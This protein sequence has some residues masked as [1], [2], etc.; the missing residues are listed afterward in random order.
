[1]TLDKEL[2]SE[3]MID[4]DIVKIVRK[5]CPESSD[6]PLLGLPDVLATRFLFWNVIWK[7]LNKLG[8]VL[9]TEG[10]FESP[11]IVLSPLESI[12]NTM[13]RN[14]DFFDDETMLL[15]SFSTDP[16]LGMQKPIQLLREEIEEYIFQFT[17]LKSALAKPDAELPSDLPPDILSCNKTTLRYLESRV[18]LQVMEKPLHM[19]ENRKERDEKEIMLIKSIVAES[20]RPDTTFLSRQNSLNALQQTVHEQQVRSA[21][22][23][24]LKGSSQSKINPMFSKGFDPRP[25]GGTLSLFEREQLRL[26]QMPPP[27]LSQSALRP[28]TNMLNAGM[29]G[30]SSVAPIVSRAGDLV[31]AGRRGFPLPCVANRAASLASIDCNNSSKNFKLSWDEIK[32]AY[33]EMKTPEENRMLDIGSSG[34]V[35]PMPDAFTDVMHPRKRLRL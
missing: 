8:W 32:N 18:K 15:R 21:I 30:L 10:N 22:E 28:N 7:Q 24:A 16:R 17:L 23:Q 2:V 20:E 25:M 34:L 6:T 13:K 4:K 31:G 19:L 11:F 9:D 27:A 29:A 33:Y 3:I 35:R 5:R 1:M 12:T 14:F 26:S